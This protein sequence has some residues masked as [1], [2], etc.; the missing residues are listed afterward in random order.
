[1]ADTKVNP[2]KTKSIREL[3]MVDIEKLKQ[4]ITSLSETVWEKETKNRENDF[5]CFHHTQHIIFRFPNQLTDR[6]IVHDNP[7]WNV[8]KPFLLPILE[9]AVEPYDYENGQIKAVMLARLKAGYGIDKHIDGS[10]S[11][12]FLH[13]IHI[14]IQTNDKALFYIEPDTY[15]LKEGIA[16]EVNNIVPHAVENLGDEDRIHLIFEYMETK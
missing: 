14:P 6:R 10:M 12:Y 8:W 4:L 7:I 2:N 1:M 11:Y 3:G 5:E 16:Y 9:K 15:H 13:K